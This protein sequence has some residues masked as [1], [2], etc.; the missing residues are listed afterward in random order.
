ME[1]EL[2][3]SLE[4]YL[5]LILPCFNEEKYMNQPAKE[6]SEEAQVNKVVEPAREAAAEEAREIVAEAREA[7]I[8]VGEVTTQ[9]PPNEI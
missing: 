7:V 8:E 4:P 6:D 3:K 1:G 5:P 2:L 9:D